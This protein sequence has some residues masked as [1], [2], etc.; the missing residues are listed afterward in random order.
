MNVVSGM[1]RASGVI[2]A[3]AAIF[4]FAILASQNTHAQGIPREAIPVNPPQPVDNDGK[5]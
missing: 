5:I 2:F 1:Q 4:T 3:A